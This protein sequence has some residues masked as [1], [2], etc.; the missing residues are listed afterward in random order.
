M[1]NLKSLYATLVLAWQLIL[2]IVKRV[3]RGGGRGLSDFIQSYHADN[4][5]ALDPH[6]KRLLYNL[7]ACVA[8]RLCEVLCPALSHSHPGNFMGPAF[9]ATG[10]SRLI[11]DYHYAELDLAACGHCSGCEAIC[12]KQVPLQKMF[13]W[14]QQKAK[15]MKVP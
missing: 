13:H 10:V 14:L 11:P 12:P 3:T 7:S 9:Y 2:H 8:C 1:F 6:E 5:S 15:G 4:I